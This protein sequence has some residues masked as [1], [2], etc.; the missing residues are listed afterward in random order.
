MNTHH[1]D[2]LSLGSS[3]HGGNEKIEELRVGLMAFRR[4]VEEI[5]KQVARQG[6]LVDGLLGERI[7]VKKE[8]ALCRQLLDLNA[9]V[10]R[11]ENRLMVV[12][13]KSSS[14]AARRAAKTNEDEE[15]EESSDDESAEYNVEEGDDVMSLT[16]SRLRRS[17][18]EVKLVEQLIAHVDHDQPLIASERARLMRVRSA[19]L[20]DLGTALKQARATG[21]GIGE[22]CLTI[23]ALY[24]DLDEA[25][26]A[27]NAL[28]G[29]RI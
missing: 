12:G 9:R 22:H 28:G 10:N 23:F 14:G 3:L 21:D 1:E 4:E 13:P 5:K 19:L 29:D 17:V 18:Q 27:V 11:L 24:R 26:A 7:R 2:F 25:V 16:I 8:I 6:Q 20:I 15:E